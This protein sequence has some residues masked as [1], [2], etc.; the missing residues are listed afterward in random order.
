MIYLYSLIVKMYVILFSM[1]VVCLLKCHTLLCCFKINVAKM[2][3][4]SG[5]CLCTGT[6][7]S[8]GEGRRV[9]AHDRHRV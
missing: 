2:D 5:V 1:V 3:A 4:C 8:A 9:G 6:L 7:V